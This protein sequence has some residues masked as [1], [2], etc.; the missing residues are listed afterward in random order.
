MLKND[1]QFSSTIATI[2]LIVVFG[3]QIPSGPL[4]GK[5]GD[6]WYKNSLNGRM[7]VVG[8]CVVAGSVFYLSAFLLD[9]TSNNLIMALIFLVLVLLGAFFFG[10]VDPLTQATL[11]EI[12]PPKIRSTIFSINYISNT[13]GRSISLLIVSGFYIAFNDLYRPGY[14][15]ISLLALGTIIFLI[16]IF[17]LL[18]EDI[19]NLKNTANNSK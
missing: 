14:I 17:K 6:K 3:G 4:F 8:L 11:G 15:F 1:Y 19:K 16:P 12:N 7:K 13:F 10:G 5:L 2:F 18:P 9:F